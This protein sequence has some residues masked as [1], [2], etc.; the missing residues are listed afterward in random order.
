MKK[1]P[2][3]LTLHRETLT[4]LSAEQAN[5][6]AGGLTT[7]GVACGGTMATCG[8]PC[9]ANCTINCSRAC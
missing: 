7:V 5:Q 3:K 2:G 8:T 4:A 6:A 1:H 9:S